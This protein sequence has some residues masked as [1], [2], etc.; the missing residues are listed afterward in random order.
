MNIVR[1]LAAALLLHCPV[2]VLAAPASPCKPEGQVIVNLVQAP[3]GAKADY[4][5]ASPVTCLRLD[6]SGT[7][8]KAV[9]TVLTAGAALSADG[10]SVQF[11]APGQTLSVLLKPPPQNL[12]YYRGTEPVLTFGDGKAVLVNTT[13]LRPPGRQDYQFRFS[14]FLPGTPERGIAAHE[15]GQA[16]RYLV[17]G[18][19]ALITLDNQVAAVD[20]AIPGWLVDTVRKELL[21]AKSSMGMII[22]KTEPFSY[23]FTRSGRNVDRYGYRGDVTPELL[24][25][26]FTGDF[27]Q[28]REMWNFELARHFVFHEYFHALSLAALDTTGQPGIMA[29]AEGG[30]E[31]VA[32]AILIKTGTVKPSDYAA[33]KD[34]ALMR[35]R[36]VEGETQ[37][38]KEDK[39]L[40]RAPYWCG[41]ALQ[42]L[43]VRS[44][45]APGDDASTLLALWRATLNN[46]ETEARGWKE[47]IAAG[48]AQGG[49]AAP[50]RLAIVQDI[51]ISRIS[52]GEG[53]RKLAELGVVRPLNAA[54]LKQ[55]EASG[56][57]RQAAINHVL[58]SNC[59]GPRSYV[60][61]HTVFPLQVPPESCP[62]LKNGFRLV[63]LNGVHLQGDG[64]KAYLEQARRC[65]AGEQTVLTDEWNRS[66]PVPCKAPG[67]ALVLYVFEP[68]KKS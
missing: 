35:C 58:D 28:K 12:A 65:A 47:M 37:A 27:W 10:R 16:S 48:T 8:R 2:A 31:A 39:N 15:V 60:S 23:V 25:L 19:P 13:H 41:E 53:L 17:V 67:P 5:F 44:L 29:L 21:H 38:D 68:A 6:G 30:S 7:L 54:E 63:W 9:W 22:D 24:R 18:T 57:Y 52:W 3:G 43:L 32:A 4:A 33:R 62:G 51:A 26:D 55:P 20:G 34:V 46:R 1:L 45:D 49:P 56:A 64:H 50:A 36:V 66:L 59:T 14:G 11:N 42:H 40:E 61:E